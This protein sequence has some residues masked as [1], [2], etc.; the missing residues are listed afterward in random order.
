MNTTRFYKGASLLSLASL[1][2]LT[3]CPEEEPSN[4][5]NGTPQ[6]DMTM[7]DMGM[8]M[9]EEGDMVSPDA[10]MDMPADMEEMCTPLTE[11][12]ADTCGMLEDG[13][14]GTIDCGPCACVDGQ[15]SEPTC[16]VCGFGVSGC[17][18]A[19]GNGPA[20]CSLSALTVN[21]SDCDRVIYVREADPVATPDGSKQSPYADVA[22]AFAAGKANG[23]SMIVLAQGSYVVSGKL[24]LVEGMHVVGGFTNDFV[25]D[26]EGTSALTITPTGPDNERVGVEAIDL[27]NKTWLK[28]LDITVEGVNAPFTLYGFHIV[29]SAGLHLEEVSITTG[30]LGDGSSGKDGADGANG[31]DGGDAESLVTLA[32]RVGDMTVDGYVNGAFA[33]AAGVNGD[34]PTN[35]NGG[36]GGEGIHIIA[37]EIAVSPFVEYMRVLP[38][39]GEPSASGTPGG[40]NGSSMSPNGMNG[41]S[42]VP[43]VGGNNGVSG[44]SQGRVVR[45]YWEIQGNGEDGEDG[46]TGT[47]GSGGGGTWWM[48]EDAELQ[49]SKPGASG[50]GGGAGGCGGEGGGGGQAGASGFGVLVVDSLG[51]IFDRVNV[52]GPDAGNGGN[53]GSGG[54][55]GVGGVGGG[56]SEQ[57]A[58]TASATPVAHPLNAGRGGTGGQGS[59]GGFGGA[60]AGGSSFGVYCDA[61]SSVERMGEVTALAGQAGA[62]GPLGSLPGENGQAE[63]VVGCW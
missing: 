54:A 30:P 49:E 7:E 2:V 27:E 35:A 50:G 29:G 47:G 19:T 5:S 3:G 41:T 51:V 26:E 11:C 57:Y 42:G 43:G 14:G 10:G 15:P 24:E 45:T 21:P 44:T 23:A 38:A 34:C 13:C 40:G 9:V 53:G 12:P 55:G 33:G 4:G 37:T 46:G 20:T 39:A 59:T 32:A 56:G 1:L 62:G 60:G 25:F 22:Q 31:G 18:Q 36:A 58:I 16:G 63:D 8:D 52:Q 28:Q 48:E 17:E 6:Q 61:G